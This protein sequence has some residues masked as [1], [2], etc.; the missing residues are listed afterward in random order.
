MDLFKLLFA[1][2]NNIGLERSY[3]PTAVIKPLLR[4]MPSSP[5]NAFMNAENLFLASFCVNLGKAA[6]LTMKT[7]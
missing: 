3:I 4:A 7:G 2:L 6:A 1:C 5:E